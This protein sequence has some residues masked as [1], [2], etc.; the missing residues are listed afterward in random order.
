MTWSEFCFCV[1]LFLCMG[2][3]LCIF[4]T[5]SVM[6]CQFRW[7]GDYAMTTKA[8]LSYH[9]LT[10]SRSVSPESSFYKIRMWRPRLLIRHHPFTHT[11]QRYSQ[12]F[13]RV[14]TELYKGFSS[15]KSE[16]NENK[17]NF[18]KPSLIMCNRISKQWKHFSKNKSP[19]NKSPE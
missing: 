2:L 12:G 13:W 14:N 3:F 10:P 6:A 9:F 11:Q 1:F 8:L 15:I 5:A 16:G 19:R 17:S 7:K 4:N 18:W